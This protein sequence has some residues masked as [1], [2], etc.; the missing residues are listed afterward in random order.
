MRW[1]NAIQLHSSNW[2]QNRNRTRGERELTWL[3]FVPGTTRGSGL[4]GQLT[5]HSAICSAMWYCS[6]EQEVFTQIEIE[7]NL[8]ALVQRICVC[9]YTNWI[10]LHSSNSVTQLTQFKC[11]GATHFYPI[12]QINTFF[13][14]RI[15]Y[16][17]VTRIKYKYISCKCIYFK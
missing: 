17:C 11:F 9:V 5:N 13:V 15:N 8:N 6:T 3:G 2:V 16:I 12:Y 14:S 1:T 4:P 10:D 7:L